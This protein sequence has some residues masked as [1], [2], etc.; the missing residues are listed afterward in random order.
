MT[1]RIDGFLLARNFTKA[2]RTNCDLIVCHDME[3]PEMPGTAHDVAAW[4]AGPRAPEA[5]AHWCVDDAQIWGCV[6]EKDVAW[7]APGANRNGIGI[8]L[9]GYANQTPADWADPYSEAVLRR[10]AALAA[11]IAARWKIPLFYVDAAGLLAGHRG[12]TTHAQVSKAFKKSTHWDPGPNFPMNHFLDL[13]RG[14][15][16]PAKEPTIVKVNAPPV[17]VLT[18]PVWPTNSY[19]I[20]CADGGVDNF[21]G[22][23]FY[24][25]EGGT[26]LNSPIT[27]AA[28]T[29]S[30]NGYWLCAADGGVFTHGDAEWHGSMGDKPLNRPICSIA[31]SPSGHGYTLLGEDGGL[32]EFGDAVYLG[33]V[34]YSAS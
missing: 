10:A 24:G 30:G 27:C 31:P 19:T 34:E 14:V 23:P 2:N 17:A 32:F 9:P 15:T 20:V 18:H 1:S 22:S 13:A 29:P 3:H 7:H 5:S 16:T 12:V 33:R 6:H 4:F 21:G 8:E 11:D 26:K 28:V 25:A